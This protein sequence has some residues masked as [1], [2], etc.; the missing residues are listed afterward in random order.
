[1]IEFIHKPVL[2]EQAVHW[3]LSNGGKY[4]VDGTLGGGG[5]TE[6]ILQSGDEYEVLGLDCDRVALQATCKR[7]EEYSTRL[8]MVKTHFSKMAEAVEEKGWTGKVDGVLLDIGVSSPQ[9]DTPERGF[10]FRFDAPLDMRMDRESPITASV[11][12]NTYGE[13][14]IANILYNYGEERC[15][16]RIA[17]AVVERRLIKPWA[18]T[19][20]FAELLE[21]IVGRSHQHG[22]PAATRSFQA[23]RIAVNHELDELKNGL[24]AAYQV[25][26]PGGILVVIS[27]HSLE[28]RVV[29]KYLRYGAA[30]CVCPP[31]LPICVCGKVKTWKI[32]TR[33]PVTAELDEVCENRRAG[34][35]KMRVGQ[36]IV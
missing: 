22:L 7:L 25:L 29:K 3:L 9:I 15:S 34:C 5:H 20:E 12:L 4:F 8:F 28:D 19:G 23:L 30:E 1:V 10:S 27:F 11:I 2:L 24:D 17:K 26:K 16:R 32:L 6:K 31:G 35:A 18:R 21:K 33:K 36:K 13:E 14:Q